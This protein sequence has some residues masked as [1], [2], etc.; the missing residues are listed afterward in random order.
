MPWSIDAD[1]PDCEGYAVVKDD[2]DTLEGCHETEEEAQS[3]VDALDASEDGDEESDAGA[4]RAFQ[5]VLM[6]LDTETRDGRIMNA[7]GF[8]IATLPLPLQAMERV[9]LGGHEGAVVIGRLDR[10]WVDDRRVMG[11]GVLMPAL[12]EEAARLVSLVEQR[13][14]RHMSV[15]GGAFVVEEEVT[16][17]NDDGEPAE[18]R[19]R[20]TEF[21]LAGA[22]I[23]PLPAFASAVIWLDGEEPPTEADAALPPAQSDTGDRVDE[24]EMMGWLLASSAPVEPPVEFFANPGLTEPTPLVVTD[25]GRVYGHLATWGTC[26]TAQPGCVQAPH[27][28]TDYAYFHTANTRVATPDGPGEIPTG[29][30]TLGT[31]HAGPYADRSE[32]VAHYEDTGCAVADICV[33]EDSVGIWFSGALRPGLDDARV[34][35]LRGAKPSGDWRPIGV[36]MELVAALMVNVAGFPVVAA[37]AAFDGRRQL[38]LVAAGT[39]T[40]PPLRPAPVK[41]DAWPVTTTSST[42]A[43][44]VEVFGHGGRALTDLVR[45]RR[46]ARADAV[47][48][49]ARLARLDARIG[50]IRRACVTA[51]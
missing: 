12:G 4:E 31:R 40:Q 13:A 1:H 7:E 41:I 37:S 42:T 33:G 3:Q 20:F 15:D 38:S 32:T 48:S 39:L 30:L 50:E 44:Q 27:S 9:S 34:R 43:I 19:M 35:E 36:G 22:T 25:D 46:L 28:P 21:E 16:Q 23:L 45:L 29:A 24:D 26:H 6:L 18:F 11:E 14:L 49:Q 8:T 17:R 10:V 47:A 5:A 51:A 2:D